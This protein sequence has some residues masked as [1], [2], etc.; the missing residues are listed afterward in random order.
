[1]KVKRAIAFILFLFALIYF[2]GL[3]VS[4]SPKVRASRKLKRADKLI[5][6]AK[7]LDPSVSLVDTVVIRDTLITRQVR[8]DTAF[9]ISTDTIKVYKDKLRLKLVKRLDTLFVEADCE[10]DTI[11]RKVKVPQQ[12]IIIRES[13]WQSL[14]WKWKAG[15]I[16]FLALLVLMFIRRLIFP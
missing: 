1:M 11:I 2:F 16:A 13:F 6:R 15:I 4:C 7:Q 12:K 14:N 8:V 3:F 5:E 10:A 9:L